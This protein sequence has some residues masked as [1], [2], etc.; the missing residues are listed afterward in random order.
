MSHLIH[1]WM[2]VF[3]FTL[4]FM[5]LRQNYLFLYFWQFL[6]LQGLCNGAILCSPHSSSSELSPQSSTLLHTWSARRQTW[7]FLQRNG[8]VGGQECFARIGKKKKEETKN[9]HTTKTQQL[10][11]LCEMTMKYSP[12]NNRKIG[13]YKISIKCLQRKVLWVTI[14]THHTCLCPRQSCLHNHPCH[15]TPTYEVCITCCCKWIHQPGRRTHL[16][17]YR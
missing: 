1:K 11:I 15:H 7:S 9:T 2:P 4:F 6:V 10:E 13:A 17:L 14:S 3:L 8:L 5:Y 16:Q 12:L